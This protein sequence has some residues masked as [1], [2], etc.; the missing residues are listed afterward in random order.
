MF[1][2]LLGENLAERKQFIAEHGGEYMKDL[3]V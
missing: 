1:D 3:D 2:V